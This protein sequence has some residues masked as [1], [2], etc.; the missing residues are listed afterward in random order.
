MK[1]AHE[2]LYQI[3]AAQIIIV[4]DLTKVHWS[5][6]KSEYSSQYIAFVTPSA[7][8]Q[9]RIMPFGMKNAVGTFQNTWKN[10]DRT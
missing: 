9:W 10:F 3:L 8:F 7:Q 6:P 1:H 5:T 4:F 2:F